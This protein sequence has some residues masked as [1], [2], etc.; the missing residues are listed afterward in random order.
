MAV[1]A[2]TGPSLADTTA[3]FQPC[4]RASTAVRDHLQSM[5]VLGRVGDISV[6]GATPATKPTRLSRERDQQLCRI[7]RREERAMSDSEKP[8]GAAEK[9]QKGPPFKPKPPFF[10]EL[11]RLMVVAIAADGKLVSRA[12]R[13]PNGPWDANGAAG[14]KPQSF[15]VMAAGLTGDGRVMVVAQPASGSGVLYI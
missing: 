12:Q 2:A 10:F 8:N 6:A 14:E 15:N 13:N 3:D 1:L 9:K 4:A 5:F 11:S 7:A